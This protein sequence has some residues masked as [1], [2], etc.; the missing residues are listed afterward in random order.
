MWTKLFL[1]LLLLTLYTLDSVDTVTD[2]QL[3]QIKAGLKFAN[4]LTTAMKTSAFMGFLGTAATEALLFI[5]TTIK[6]VSLIF[7]FLGNNESQELLAIKQLYTEMNRRFDV[8]DTELVDIKRQI[9]WTRVSNQF[10]KTERDITTVSRLYKNI[11]EGPLAIRKSEKSYF[12][13]SFENTCTNC[14]LDLYHGI[15]GV[16]KGLSDD[17]LQTVMTSLQYNRPQMQTFMLGILK[18]LVLGL[19]NELAYRKL[20]FSDADYLYIKG[21]WEPRLQSVTEKMKNINELI[22]TK[23]HNQAEKDIV[24]FSMKHP[25]R[26]Q[27][28]DWRDWLVIVYKPISGTQNH[29][30]HVCDGYRRYG[31]YDR[32]ILVASVDQT[33]KPINTTVAKSII[34][35]VKTTYTT[36]GN[37]C[38]AYMGH[39]V[40]HEHFNKRNAEQVYLTIPGKTRNCNVYASVGVID[41]WV[42]LWYHGKPERLVQQRTPGVNSY[43]IH[44]FG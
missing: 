8:I 11:Y 41:S 27:K 36:Y 22:K 40:T 28:Y 2:N 29:I 38:G 6:F 12:I 42:D 32:D 4:D 10:S 1:P 35:G 3:N 16:N 24:S 7:S 26:I 17:I 43:S 25:S 20:K 14:A 15:M 9:N 13:N 34:D 44:L 18:L 33:K 23:Y 5:S 30:N 21:Q 37:D 39:C 19:N 31:I